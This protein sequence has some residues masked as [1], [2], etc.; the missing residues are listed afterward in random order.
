L[1]IIRLAAAWVV[2]LE[3]GVRGTL[4][5][6]IGLSLVV[7]LIVARKVPAPISIPIIEMIRTRRGIS[8]PLRLTLERWIVARLFLGPI[9]PKV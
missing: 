3:P 9:F 4:K 1:V 8:Q 5:T 7:E 2:I 6:L